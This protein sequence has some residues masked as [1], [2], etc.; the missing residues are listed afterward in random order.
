MVPAPRAPRTARPACATRTARSTPLDTA[1]DTAAA[2]PAPRAPIS[3]S[4]PPIDETLQVAADLHHRLRAAGHQLAHR[5]RPLERDQEA[6]FPGGHDDLVVAEHRRQPH[7]HVERRDRGLDLAPLVEHRAD[8]D[9]GRLERRRDARV[10]PG[11]LGVAE[12]ERAGAR[13]AKANPT[14]TRRAASS[15]SEAADRRG[16]VGLEE[17]Q[18]SP[19][20]R[21]T[22]ASWSPASSRSAPVL[23]ADARSPKSS[24]TGN[25]SNVPCSD[26]HTLRRSS[27]LDHRHA[28]NPRLRQLTGPGRGAGDGRRQE[29][30]RRRRLERGRR[31][32]RPA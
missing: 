2:P 8:L 19:P 13:R 6:P 12:P 32:R 20:V 29:A 5:R 15:V 4:T 11:E 18:H 7:P 22:E 17:P 24:V 25:V 28:T 3:R 23:A 14:S 21:K 27:R 31:A 30:P 10:V 1:G 16:F 26:T 9:D